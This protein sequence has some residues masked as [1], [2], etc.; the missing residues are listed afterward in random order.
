MP[1][2]RSAQSVRIEEERP[3]S[4]SPPTF[5]LWYDLRNPAQWRQPL[6]Q[7]YRDTLDQAV[8]AEGLGF[9]S[10]WFSE[11]HFSDD[12]YTSAP[13]TMCAA[14]GA[15]TS[16]MRIGTNIVVSALHDPIRLAEDATAISLLTDGRFELGLGLGYHER[17]FSAFGRRL[18]QRPSL[19]EDSIEVIKHAWTAD[20]AR[21]QG[22]RFSSPELPITPKPEQTPR[23]LIGAQSQ[24]GIDRA[25]RMT[26]GVITLS[27]DHF[28][29]YLDSVEQHGGDVADARIYASQWVVV[30]EDPD[31]VWVEGLGERALFQLNEYIAWGSF[32]GPDQ[33]DR[34]PDA[35]SLLDAGLYR[36]QDASAAVD[37]LVALALATPQVRD[38]HYW[39][40]LPGET[41]ESG[42]ARIQYMA[43]KVIPEVTR[44]LAAEKQPA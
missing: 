2:V 8:W 5:G 34:F 13:L 30:A 44:R 33:P 37:D 43:D 22:K 20:S 17:E 21:H 29:W 11:H 15:R 24:V 40:Q 26:D 7:L 6:G 31:K 14:L 28:Q 27:N 25:A 38:F 16:T 18:K 36:L 9:G 12:D 32:E 41:V 4:Q 42:S 39:A 19:F 1:R 3:M 23:I 10:A 35:Q